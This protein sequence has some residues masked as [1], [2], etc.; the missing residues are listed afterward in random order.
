MKQMRKMFDENDPKYQ[1]IAAHAE[2]GG[3]GGG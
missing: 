3:G 1:K 2:E